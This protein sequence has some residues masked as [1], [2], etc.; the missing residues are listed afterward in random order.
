MIDVVGRVV[1]KEVAY[2]TVVSSQLRVEMEGQIERL[3]QDCQWEAVRIPL[4]MATRAYLPP[5]HRKEYIAAQLAPSVR[6]PCRGPPSPARKT[7][8]THVRGSMKEVRM[9]VGH[10]GYACRDLPN[11]SAVHA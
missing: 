3:C 6:T 9:V 4:W 1:I 2:V 5:E 8:I 10:L 7:R 11:H